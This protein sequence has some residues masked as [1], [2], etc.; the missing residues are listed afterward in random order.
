MNC[1]HCHRFFH[2]PKTLEY[3]A[4][5]KSKTIAPITATAEQEAKFPYVSITK[6][7]RGG[8]EERMRDVAF[9][10]LGAAGRRAFIV[11]NGESSAIYRPISEVILTAEELE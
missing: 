3:A 1:P 4:A 10:H 8:V 2:A 5:V 6:W 9:A 7:Y 11:Q